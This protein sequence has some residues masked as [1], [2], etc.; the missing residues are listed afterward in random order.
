[1]LYKKFISAF[2][3]PIFLCINTFSDEIDY[4]SPENLLK[5][6]DHLYQQGDYIRSAKEYERYMLSCPSESDKAL[7]KIG[8]CYR[9]T[10]NIDKAI[11]SFQKIANEY[12]NSEFKF[13]ANF[14]IGYSYFVSGQYKK[15]QDYTLNLLKD[16][17]T[18]DQRKKLYVLLALNYLKQKE[19][20]QANSVF[21]DALDQPSE[22]QYIDKILSDLKRLSLDGINRK[23]K[24]RFWA[25]L[26][27]AIIPG[28]GKVYCEQYGNGLYSFITVGSIGFIAYKGFKE[29]GIKSIKGWIFGSIFPIFYFGNIYG[30]G[31]SALAYNDYVENEII[32]RLP[33]LPDD[34]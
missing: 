31:I 20:Q 8:L 22:D 27:S 30:S 25:S 14:Q 32:V 33:I 2:L 29:N 9:H 4:Y 23:H 10:E 19:W 34:W 12:P 1:M 15:S 11:Y 17:L 28:T 26:M 5:F 13:S 3:F 21:N 18:V 24:S 7:H 6:A 16:G